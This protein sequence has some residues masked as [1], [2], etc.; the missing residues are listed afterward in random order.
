MST[1][2]SLRYQSLSRS[3]LV[4]SFEFAWIWCCTGACDCVCD[5]DCMRAW[6]FDELDDDEDEFVAVVVVVVLVRLST[7]SSL[8]LDMHCCCRMRAGFVVV[9]VASPFIILDSE[10]ELHVF[11]L[12][13][14]V[15]EFSCVRSAAT[16]LFVVV[17]VVFVGGAF[18]GLFY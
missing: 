14:F 16:G 4:A 8:L 7:S 15:V 17:V 3:R 11:V 9:V 13:V 2:S 6:F 1:S 5:C 10:F 12:R 18:A